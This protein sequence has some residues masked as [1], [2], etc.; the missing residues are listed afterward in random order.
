M[1]YEALQSKYPMDFEAKSNVI[2]KHREVEISLKNV[3]VQ[4]YRWWEEVK[5]RKVWPEIWT[6]KIKKENMKVNGSIY[7]Q[8]DKKPNMLHLRT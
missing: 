7:G 6:K 5:T 2:A 4:H 1:F 8:K 3:K